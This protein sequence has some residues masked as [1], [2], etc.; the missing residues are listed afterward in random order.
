MVS[1]WWQI[2]EIVDA[3]NRLIETSPILIGIIE[4]VAGDYQELTQALDSTRHKIHLTNI[5][6]IDEAST[7]QWVQLMDRAASSSVDVQAIQAQQMVQG[8]ALV[9]GLD[10]ATKQEVTLLEE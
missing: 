8:A 7:S 1:W 6:P 9:S 10:D 3:V 2:A 5:H 4:N